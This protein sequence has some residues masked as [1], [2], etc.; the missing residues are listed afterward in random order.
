MP[1]PPQIM[2]INISIEMLLWGMF[3]A[4]SLQGIK[5]LNF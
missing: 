4:F 1:F 5:N 2:E 3:K